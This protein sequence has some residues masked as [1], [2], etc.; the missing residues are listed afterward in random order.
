MRS[1]P[2]DAAQRAQKL[3]QQ[4]DHHNYLYHVKAQ[5]KISDREFDALMRE[6]IDLETQYPQLLTP[7]S[8][9]LRLGV[10]PIDWF[11]TV[12]HAV[13]MMSIDNTYD[14]AE[15]RAFDTR[16]RKALSSEKV[17]YVLE[18][19]VDGVAA[20]IRYERGRLALAATRGDG[21]RGDDI[22]SNA[23]TIRSL[24][25]RLENDGKA[26]RI[27]EVRGEIFMPNDVFQKLNAQREAA[28]EE[29]F[30]NPRNLTTSALKQLDPKIT[31]SRKLQF[32]SHG[33]GQ[34]E[35]MSGDSYWDW[36][37]QLQEWRIPVAEHTTLA[38]DV[39]EVLAAI[40][41]FEQLR[42]KLTY[43][44]DG[45]VTKLDSFAQRKR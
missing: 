21:R 5:P 28:G 40:E 41:E 15:V 29:T 37:K 43:Q 39:D 18:P 19:K 34:V 22:T 26:P 6:L 11:K 17:K 33:L 25:L 35:P 13:P 44:T 27:L 42:G 38:K 7:D 30:K 32:V 24:P 12:E 31:A 2:I 20:S 16:V 1:P 10:Q 14:E 3:R 45:M 9:S 23:K 8:P 4:L 36:L